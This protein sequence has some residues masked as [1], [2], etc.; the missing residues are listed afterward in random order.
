MRAL[1]ALPQ[2]VSRSNFLFH[3][4]TMKKHWKLFL[5]A[6]LN[7]SHKPLVTALYT[8]AL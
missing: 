8:A 6:Y 2:V 5:V 3:M 7:I 4:L 1:K